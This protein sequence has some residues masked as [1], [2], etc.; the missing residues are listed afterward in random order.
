MTEIASLNARKRSADDSRRTATFTLHA[1]GTITRTITSVDGIPEDNKPSPFRHLDE[2]HHRR[3][4]ADATAGRLYLAGVIAAEGWMVTQ[5]C[6][7]PRT[8]KRPRV[9]THPRPLKAAPPVALQEGKLMA[10]TIALVP[11]LPPD[12]TTDCAAMFARNLIAAD[13]AVAAR[14]ALA[15][16]QDAGVAAILK[17]SAPS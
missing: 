14:I 16:A 5:L 7:V 2:D 15:L 11:P 3:Y 17:A 9:V 13:P 1:D 10:A 12:A 6:P 8:W 4:C